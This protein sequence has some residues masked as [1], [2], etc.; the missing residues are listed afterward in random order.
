MGYAAITHI[1]SAIPSMA[2]MM[3]RMGVKMH[4]AKGCEIFGQDEDANLMH[5]V[6]TG[7]VRTTRLLSDGRRQVG[8]FYFEDDMIGCANGT[9]HRFSAEALVDCSV[10]VVRR[11]VF[12]LAYSDG[13]L[14]NA[15]LEATR[16]EL[17]RTQDHLLALGG[18]SACER[19]ASFLLG[20]AR[21][22]IEWLSLPMGRQDMA[23]YLDLTIET[24]SRMVRHLQDLDVVKF[25][26]ARAFRVLRHDALCLLAA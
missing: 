13:A 10:W 16:R 12:G 6:A 19:V 22:D 1:T 5:C 15:L 24:V 20:F 14:A 9:I 2:A 25:N 18:K 23:D 26:G 7:A 21:D 3:D 4:F 11:S 17:E 8:D